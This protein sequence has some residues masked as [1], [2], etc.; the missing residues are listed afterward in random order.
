MSETA[1][2]TPSDS[3]SIDNAVIRVENVSKLFRT[4]GERNIGA[5]PDG[6]L[7]SPG[8]AFRPV[9]GPSGGG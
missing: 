8:S 6:S 4:P 7:Y 3:R 2:H 1:T 5:R 9:V